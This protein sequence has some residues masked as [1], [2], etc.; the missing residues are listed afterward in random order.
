MTVYPY[1][2]TTY[3]GILMIRVSTPDPQPQFWPSDWRNA[4]IIPTS[5]GSTLGSVLCL[6]NY[7]LI[8]DYIVMWHLEYPQTGNSNSAAT[9]DHTHSRMRKSR[10]VRWRTIIMQRKRMDGLPP[11]TSGYNV[12]PRS[13]NL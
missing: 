8:S 12:R 13:R 2:F 7:T 4:I 6:R 1:D 11:W 10:T 3:M 5:G 9:K